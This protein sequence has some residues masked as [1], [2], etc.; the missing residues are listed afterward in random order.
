[1]HAHRHRPGFECCILVRYRRRRYDR[2]KRKGL[3]GGRYWERLWRG[4][5]YL[6]VVWCV[7]KRC[8]RINKK[9]AEAHLL[10]SSLGGKFERINPDRFHR[11]GGCVKIAAIRGGLQ[12]RVFRR[13]LQKSLRPVDQ[14][15]AELDVRCGGDR[16]ERRF[17]TTE[18]NST[19]EQK[20]IPG[21]AYGRST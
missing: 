7:T 16:C 18:A 1:M 13:E 10:E 14:G 2:G 15:N 3:F 8:G 5:R 17:E 20:K 11:L 21:T 9:Y 6:L 12:E 19:K 4:A